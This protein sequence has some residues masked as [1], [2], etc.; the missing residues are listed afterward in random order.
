[1]VRRRKSFPTAELA[2]AYEAQ[3]KATARPKAPRAA[4]PSGGPVNSTSLPREA[5]QSKPPRTSSAPSPEIPP[6]GRS[7]KRTPSPSPLGGKS[8]KLPQPAT[9]V[10]RPPSNLYGSSRK[11]MARK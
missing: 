10:R 6:S 7:T 8:R 2:L 3:Q 1:G 9:S 11:S 5:R 4:R